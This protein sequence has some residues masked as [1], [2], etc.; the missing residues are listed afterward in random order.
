[1]WLFDCNSKIDEVTIQ[2]EEVCDAKWANV[3]ELKRLYDEGKFEANAYFE[4]IL[5]N[6]K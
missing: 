6:Y 1:M 5:E 3:D 2:K 4:Y